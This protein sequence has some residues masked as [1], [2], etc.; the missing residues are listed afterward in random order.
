MNFDGR[1]ELEMEIIG[2]MGFNGGQIARMR[3]KCKSP[4]FHLDKDT[5]A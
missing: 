3:I 2:L 1:V 5:T 4:I